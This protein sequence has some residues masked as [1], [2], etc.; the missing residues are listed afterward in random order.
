M[1]ALAA[2]DSGS[3][4]NFLVPNGTFI[5]EIIAFLI[6]LA[7]LGRYVLPRINKALED[8]Q[9][10]IRAQ[11]EASQK[12]QHD[13]AEA[14]DEYKKQLADAREEATRMREDARAQ[15]AAIIAQ[16]REQAQAEAKKA[17]ELYRAKLAEARH[18]AS[19]MREEAR[20]Q[21]AQIIAEMR[22]EAQAEARRL[23][24]AAQAQIE[25]ERQQALT[26]LRSEVG[27]MATTLASRIVGESLEDEQRQSRVVDRFL[28]D[29]EA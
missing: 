17:L 8:R 15:G 2:A 1:R 12:A 14:L 25:A 20:E 9:E 26:S 13:A 10:Q 29:L 28:A 22:Q 18:E 23:T 5:V 16:M 7:I 4:S 21:G 27:Q 3:S 19:R 11:F 6:M 24:E